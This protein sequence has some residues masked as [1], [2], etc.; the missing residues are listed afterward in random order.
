M[1][2]LLLFRRLKLTTI[3]SPFVAYFSF[4]VVAQN[5][6]N[7]FLMPSVTILVSVVLTFF[8]RK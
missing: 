1:T 6:R 2:A 7:L 3:N 5:S 8:N 4:M